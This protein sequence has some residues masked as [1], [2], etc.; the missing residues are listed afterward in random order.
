[1]IKA[2]LT[3]LGR[4]LWR[5]RL[6]T[7][8]NIL[9]LSVCISVAWI[10][11]RMVDYEYSYDR[12][13][14]EADRIYQ[15]ISK[16][17]SSS[18]ELSTFAGVSKPVY[19]TLRNEIAGAELTVPMFYI[20]HH[21]AAVQ[22]REKE[23]IR[24]AK[25]GEE[26]DIEIVTTTPSYFTVLPHRFLAGE[27]VSALDAP[28]KVVLTDTRARVYFPGLPAGD[29]IGKTITYDDSL[30]RRVSGVVAAFDFPNSFENN[31]EFMALSKKDMASDFWGGMSSSD[32]LFVKP[33]RG[34]DLSKIMEHLNRIN[35]EHKRESFE[36]Y[37][38]KSWYELMPLPEKH[39]E[40]SLGAQTRTADKKVL[41]GLMITA[42][43]LLLLACINYVNL[44]T[45]QL[46][47][48]AKEIGIRK[49]LGS[50][51]RALISRFIFE[52]MAV[53]V[54]AAFF[55]FGFTLLGVRWLADFLPEGLDS[56]M[57]YTGM[58]AFMLLLVLGVSLFS[59]FYP[60]WLSAR[61]NTVN[62]L[63]GVTEKVAGR[64]RFSLRKGLI[65]FQ[66]VIA[67]VFIIGSII[68]DR[69]IQFSLDKDPGFNKERVIT[70]E[71]P[72]HIQNDKALRDKIGI[73]KNELKRNTPVEAVSVGSRP[74]DNTMWGNVFTHYRDTAEYQGMAH[75]KFGD[76][77]YLSLYEF[78]LLAGRNF[79]P[80]DT[81]NEIVVNEK[82]LEVYGLGSPQEAI[83][84]T[85]VP[86]SN[87]AKVYPV[88]GVVSDF[89][90][91]GVK[92][93]INASVIATRK[94]PGSVLNIK[95]PKQVKAWPDAIRAIEKEWKAVYGAVPFTYTFYD[96]TVK[97][98]YEGEMRTR[99]LVSAATTIAILISCLGLFGLAT[100]TAYSRTKEIGVRKVLGASV[101]NITRLLSSE[102]LVLVLVSVVIA[103]P[104]AW[105]MMNKW[106]QDFVF[107]IDIEAWMFVVAAAGAA[108]IALLTVSYQ[109]IRAAVANPVNA[110]RSE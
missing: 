66:F 49:T 110:L 52:T 4:Q 96:D 44:S 67:Q 87:K 65:V 54:L 74:M 9:G 27:P 100:L 63:K 57:N 17:E 83:G 8:L 39:F 55:S 21:H 7:F 89:Q 81:M 72:Y 80:S 104:I 82:A 56:Y 42:A 30:V 75:M 40:A 12:R 70:V 62:V 85:L 37:K 97:K 59:G 29:I 51:K 102:F 105:W 48:R 3:T 25:A 46:P 6:Y 41:N 34:A 61:V 5:N 91:F 103:S 93:E 36:K 28:D 18:G 31:H 50:S 98:F 77:D 45:A 92:S 79:M 101:F 22:G 107:R 69:Q 58:M 38:Y 19:H 99:K 16:D 10:I 108:C 64:N 2:F 43:F 76:A 47:Q 68:I 106:L 71:V 73:L 84:K 15:V 1:M 53:T 26:A 24:Q 60:A 35:T 23:Q 109:A 94:R 33:A 78:R 20:T 14:P 32:L 11:F 95:L 88:V 86:P 90:Q 13:I